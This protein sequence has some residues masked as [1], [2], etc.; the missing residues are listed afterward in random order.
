MVGAV[1]VGAEV[2]GLM[3]LTVRGN[4]ENAHHFTPEVLDD[5]IFP[6][7]QAPTVPAMRRIAPPA[8]MR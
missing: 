8:V 5:A 3:S 1:C 6:V 7:V 4:A 2:R